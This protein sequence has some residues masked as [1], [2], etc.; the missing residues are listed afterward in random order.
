MTLKNKVA[1][2]LETN[3]GKYL[4]GGEISRKL[5][6][7]RAGVWKA[8]CALKE[9]GYLID[10]VTNKGYRLSEDSD[11]LSA[12]EI[13]KLLPENP[14]NNEIII[15]DT[16]TSTNS[17]LRS[18]AA[19][20]AAEGTA[21]IATRQTGGR[22]RLGR[23]FFSPADTGIYMSIL[24][25]PAL[26][27]S[28]SAL[29]TAAAAVAVCDAVQKAGGPAPEIKWV[30]DIL[31][32]GKKVCGILTEASFNMESGLLDYAVLGIG[33]NVYPPDTGFPEDISSVAGALFQKRRGGIKNMLVAAIIESFF[34]YYGSLGSRSFLEAYR[35][36]CRL[37]GRRITVLKGGKEIPALALSID[38][39][40]RLKVRY[41]DGSEEL[42]FSGEISV[43]PAER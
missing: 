32:D 22:G 5:G 43:R 38:D 18:M 31:V 15:Y 34:G 42:L 24:L 27:A 40:C 12:G 41:D 33:I 36:R 28:E 11:V 21:V 26:A 20:G 14:S 30:N 9:E 7:S 39:D 10:A 17:V 6:V 29:I 1:A 3:R 23:S 19:E 37:P 13:K 2:L 8:V 16:V 25:R 4:S 35:R